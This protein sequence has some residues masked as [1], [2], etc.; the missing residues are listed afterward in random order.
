VRGKTGW[1]GNRISE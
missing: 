1:L